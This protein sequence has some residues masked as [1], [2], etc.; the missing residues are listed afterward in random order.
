MIPDGGTWRRIVV[1]VIEYQLNEFSTR[2]NWPTVST[3]LVVNTS[4]VDITGT[5][6]PL[7]P[8]FKDIQ[9]P[10][11][12]GEFAV[13]PSP[14]KV[15]N[16]LS[17]RTESEVDNIGFNI[18]RSETEAEVYDDDGGIVNYERISAEMI[19]GA[20]T[21]TTPQEYSYL[22]RTADSDKMYFYKIEQIDA[23]GKTAFFGPV[24]LDK[25][26]SVPI[27]FVLSQ[28]IPSIRTRRSSTTCHRTSR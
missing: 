17:W 13:L 23:S 22:D 25:S 2:I 14:Q 20:G 8:E 16:L 26:E 27:D 7:G 9:L 24:A 5:R 6:I 12:F 19:P 3:F 28:P 10:V 1:I 11:Q 21:S 4:D 18:W 15:G